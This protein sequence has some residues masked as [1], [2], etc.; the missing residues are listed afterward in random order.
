MVK[1]MRSKKWNIAFLLIEHFI[2]QDD[3]ENFGDVGDV[4]SFLSNDGEDG[5]SLYGTIKQNLTEH[6][7][8]SSKGN[9]ISCWLCCILLSSVLHNTVD[10]ILFLSP[11]IGF[12][13]GEVGCIRTRNKVTCCHFSSD[14]KLLA[15]A[16]HDKKVTR[17]LQL[18]PKL[19]TSAFS[20]AKMSRKIHA[21]KCLVLIW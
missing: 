8:E 7:T 4:E 14:G 11:I 5:R 1:C 12:S 6:K 16:G 13:F 9:D 21:C 2:L 17:I 15:S 3:M 19:I 18:V 20:I 10:T